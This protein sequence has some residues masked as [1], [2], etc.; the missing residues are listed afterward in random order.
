LLVMVA[1]IAAYIPARK[2]VNADSMSLLKID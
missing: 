2:A 1:F